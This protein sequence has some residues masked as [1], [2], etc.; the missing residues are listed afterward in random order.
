MWRIYKLWEKKIGQN[1][2]VDNSQKR[3]S[4]EITNKSR[5][6]FSTTPAIRGVE[7]KTTVRIHSI[8]K[9]WQKLTLVK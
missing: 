1:L 2:L 9:D 5:Q 3:I 8:L 6:R 4:V 7:L